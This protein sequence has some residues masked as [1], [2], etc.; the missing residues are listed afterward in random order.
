MARSK[1][2]P[3]N[4]PANEGR[5]MKYC[6][7]DIPQ[8]DDLLGRTLVMGIAVKMPQEKID[9]IKMGIARAAKAL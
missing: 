4:D 5:R 9:A 7:E 1:G 8:A 6:R 3:F 2:Y